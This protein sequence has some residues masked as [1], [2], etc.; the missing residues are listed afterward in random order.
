MNGRRAAIVAALVT[1]MLL[2]AGSAAGHGRSVSYSVWTF[3]DDSVRVRAR[4]SRL[5][6]TRLALDPVA[7]ARDSERAALLLSSRLRLTVGDTP[8]PKT[9]A[10]IA[11]PAEKGWV[12]YAWSLTCSGSGDRAISSDLY[13]D[14]TPTHMHFARVVRGERSVERV[15]TE[16]DPLWEVEGVIAP[17][18]GARAGGTELGDYLG[19]GVEHILSGWD[20]LAFVLALLLLATSVREVA[21]LVTAFTAAHSVTLG[22]AVLGVVHPEARVVEAMIGFSIA[23]VAAENAWVLGGRSLSIPV[24][25]VGALVALALLGAGGVPR[26]AYLGLALFT[27]CHFALLRDSPRPV[28]LRAAVAFAFGLVHG[29]GFAG[30]LAEMDL[31]VDRVVPALFGFNIG[32]ELGQLGVVAVT[33]PLLRVLAR[34]HSGGIERRVT[35]IASAAICGLGIFWF[36]T[37]SFA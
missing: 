7:S 4:I 26:L 2:V 27:S 14:L 15:L 12:V 6:L 23:L 37:R 3:G 36:I 11:S 5:E 31:P 8:C 18:T 20:H 32:V 34:M 35:E 13:L 28:L 19:I 17:G 29:F 25:G 21:S 22:M 9:G 24:I 1:A 30:V 10:P 16:A 33:W